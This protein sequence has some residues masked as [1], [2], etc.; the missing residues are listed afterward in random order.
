VDWR[1]G[2]LVADYYVTYGQFPASR[3]RSLNLRGM[4]GSGSNGGPKPPMTRTDE[5]MRVGPRNQLPPLAPDWVLWSSEMGDILCTAASVDTRLARRG[6]ATYV[7]GIARRSMATA[8]S[9]N[10]W[11]ERRNSCPRVA[12]RVAREGAWIIPLVGTYLLGRRALLP[13]G[14][15]VA[16]RDKLPIA[17]T[18]RRLRAILKEN[19]EATASTAHR[20]RASNRRRGYRDPVIYGLSTSK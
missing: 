19:T 5:S 9:H 7:E 1:L 8:Q 2:A 20:G 15:M 6:L 12:C 11:A 3:G 13:A 10:V 4:D 18:A 17:S 16:I 14:P